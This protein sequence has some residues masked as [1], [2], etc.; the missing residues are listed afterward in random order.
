MKHI[1]F[2]MKHAGRFILAACMMTSL[3]LY[4]SCDEVYDNIKDFSVEETVYP[5]HVDTVF[6]SIGYER[7]EI[8]LSKYGRIPSSQINLGKAKKTIIEYD[9]IRIVY[10][11]LCSWANIRGLAQ[12]KLYR[13]SIYTEDEYGDR[14]TPVEIAATP[15]TIDDINALALPAPSVY[16]SVSSGMLEWKN[17]VSGE[18]FDFLGYEYSYT[19][20]DDN[21]RNGSG[22]G[23]YPSFLIQNITAG[24][25]VNITMNCRIIPKIEGTPILDMVTWSY[26]VSFS[27]SGSR[28]TLFLDKPADG[29]LFEQ[30]DFPIALS[31]IREAGINEYAILLSVDNSFPEN[32]TKTIN[33]GNAI[34]YSLQESDIADIE[35]AD[36]GTTYYWKVIVPDNS[37]I[38]SQT[39]QFGI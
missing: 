3:S 33:V 6:V 14:S 31:W 29:A 16:E 36:S 2:L 22:T 11:S 18:L 30:A 20:K 26:K 34:S 13:F 8:D 23:D 15:Y 39:R 5:A 24:Q 12:S 28:T 19:D 38:S 7:V 25:P 21:K 27:I 17:S 4:L 9:N 37:G 32:A 10:D 35:G 1:F